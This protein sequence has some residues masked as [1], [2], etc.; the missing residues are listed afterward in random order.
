MLSYM[1]Y[2]VTINE[3]HFDLVVK[4]P[5]LEAETI[6]SSATLNPKLVR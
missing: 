1:A 6:S 4:G 2:I 5:R 3:S